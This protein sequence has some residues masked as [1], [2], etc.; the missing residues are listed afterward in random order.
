M[1]EY[2]PEI[3]Q[4][5]VWFSA[6]FSYHL[7]NLN[8]DY[9]VVPGEVTQMHGAAVGLIITTQTRI[10]AYNDDKLTQ[11]AEYGAVPGQ[12][13]DVAADGKIYFWSK[14]GLCRALPFENV[15]ESAVSVAPGVLAGGGIINSNGYVK[16]VAVLNQGGSAFNIR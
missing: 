4:T 14:R 7:F 11:L 8:S 10:F 2:I 6:E 3:D 16:Y 13:A 12:H 9:I 15:T 5:V 1:A